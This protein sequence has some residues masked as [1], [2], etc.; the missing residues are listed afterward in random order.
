MF[1]AIHT[2]SACLLLLSAALQGE[3]I[4]RQ[5][6]LEA[7]PGD[8]IITAQGK[9]RVLLNIYAQDEGT[10]ILEE[11]IFPSTSSPTIPWCQW[12]A[13]GAPGHTSWA[14]YALNTRDGTMDAGYSFTQQGWVE[15]QNADLF[16]SNLLNLNF[17]LIPDNERKR[18][19]GHGG[20]AATRQLRSLW[21]PKMILDGQY[22]EGVLF[23]G[24]RARWPHDNSQ[25]SGKVIEIYLPQDG[26]RYL[27]HFPYW[28]EVSGMVG[29][30]RVRIIDSGKGMVSPRPA[31]TTL[32]KEFL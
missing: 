12:V 14:L 25:L 21:Q 13:E 4:L 11:I 5:Q 2:L 6:L 8:F 32:Q 27:T 28:L 26:K 20:N 30:A 9:T 17:S 24:W 7:Q 31:L 1:K 18:V 3:Q 19:G 22:I 16:L 10:L 15:I 23:N 29:K